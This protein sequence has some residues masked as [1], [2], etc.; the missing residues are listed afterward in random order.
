MSAN[1]YTSLAYADICEDCPARHE[2]S[3]YLKVLSSAIEAVGFGVWRW[4]LETD[5][6]SWDTNMFRLFGQNPESFSPDYNKFCSIIVPEDR[7][8][9]DADIRRAVKEKSDWM[10]VFRAVKPNGDLVYVRAYGKVYNGEPYM[11]GINIPITQKDFIDALAPD[12]ERIVTYQLQAERK[13]M[14][15]LRQKVSQL[16]SIDSECE[17]SPPEQFDW[18]PFGPLMEQAEWR[19]VN[20]AQDADLIVEFKSTNG[21]MDLHYHSHDELVVCRKG[22]MRLNIE[23]ETFTLLPG[24]SIFIPAYRYHSVEWL[25]DSACYITWF[26][27]YSDEKPLVF[28]GKS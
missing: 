3:G 11:A 13:K 12:A 4:N 7:R 23:H 22:S 15:R 9:V 1:L 18:V 6:I 21:A 10:N 14:W 8:R 19:R 5:I 28:V 25:G 2:K 27:F 17:L 24:Q 16:L 20:V 26:D